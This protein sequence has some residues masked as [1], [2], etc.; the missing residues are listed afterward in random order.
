MSG[1][2]YV[3]P[4]ICHADQTPNSEFF[5]S[6]LTLRLNLSALTLSCESRE[7]NDHRVHTRALYSSSFTSSSS[8][9]LRSSA[10]LPSSLSALSFFLS[11]SPVVS[12][13]FAVSAVALVAFAAAVCSQ[14]G[15]SVALK[16]AVF[17]QAVDH[18]TQRLQLC[19]HGVCTERRFLRHIKLC[20]GSF[21]SVKPL[22]DCI[23]LV[24]HLGVL[25][26]ICGLL[27]A[28]LGRVALS[29]LFKKARAILL[30][31]GGPSPR[32]RGKDAVDH[33]L[34][35]L[36]ALVI[37]LGW[38]VFALVVQPFF[39]SLERRK[40]VSALFLSRHFRDIVLSRVKLVL[41]RVQE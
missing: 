12:S 37:L 16:M 2:T 33:F 5:E 21:L 1:T 17:S 30:A 31:S 38:K 18:G 10:S 39:S 23:R 22:D 6:A 11:P 4:A 20:L 27:F 15:A 28:H 40:N 36:Q 32:V 14:R 9:P 29:V 13:T 8:P 34:D 41:A 7:L 19:L 3:L 35:L 26:V 24:A 25:G